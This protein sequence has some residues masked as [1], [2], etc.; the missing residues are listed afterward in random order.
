MGWWTRRRAIAGIAALVVAGCT[1]NDQQAATTTSTIAVTTTTLS[2]RPADGTLSIGA[3]LPRT[4]SGAAL[5]GPMIAA[6]EQAVE[7]I[8]IAGGVLGQRVDFKVVDESTGHGADEL[9]ADGVDAIVGPA[10]STVAL[11]QLADAVN[12]VTG[13]VTCSPS[14]TALALDDFPD[15]KL[16]F[17]TVPSDSFEMVAIERRVEGT[18]VESVAVGYLDDPYGRALKDVLVGRI[19]AANEV[20]LQAQ[21]GFDADQEELGPVAQQ[22]LAGGPGVV[23]VLGDADDGTRLLQALD[24]DTSGV[25]PPLVV[26]NDAIR[27]GRQGIQSLS[28]SFRS[29]L[30]GVAPLATTKVQPGPEGFFTANAADCV[31]LIALSAIQAGSDDPAEIKKNMASVSSGG[32]LCTDFADCAQR[33]AEGL[34]IDYSGYSGDVELSATTGDRTRAWFEAFSF[35][36]DGEDQMIDDPFEIVFDR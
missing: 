31:N 6:V 20:T 23:V 18:G 27:D 32:Q 36:E 2:P 35:N 34:S 9:L 15:N 5:G 21:V 10:S 8:N 14:A 16:F 22:L 13:V 30:S 3:F 28:A 33:L 25:R 24:D 19:R 11:S 1:G 26:V 7:Q 4:G 29:R 12:P 17:R